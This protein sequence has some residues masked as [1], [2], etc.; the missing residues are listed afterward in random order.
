ML[1]RLIFLSILI[2]VREILS[3]HVAYENRLEIWE[4]M[5]IKI[6]YSIKDHHTPHHHQNKDPLS[7]LCMGL[8]L[9]KKVSIITRNRALFSVILTSLST[10]GSL[11]LLMRKDKHSRNDNNRKCSKL[12]KHYR[13]E[14]IIER[15]LGCS[16]K[17]KFCTKMFLTITR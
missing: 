17:I 5:K 16:S 6:F 11:P 7:M 4:E 1:I 2:A 9:M 12:K 10:K 14:E 3:S 15:L 13:E 8:K